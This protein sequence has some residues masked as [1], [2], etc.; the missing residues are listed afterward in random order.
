MICL[1]EALFQCSCKKYGSKWNRI[2]E[3]E[4]MQSTKIILNKPG[5]VIVGQG[6]QGLVNTFDIYGGLA[7][8]YSPVLCK[9]KWSPGNV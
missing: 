8:V 6:N 3:N 4:K 5:L 2:E 1:S 7:R 9:P